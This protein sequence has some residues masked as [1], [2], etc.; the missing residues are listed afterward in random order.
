M[1]P[2]TSFVFR[3]IRSIANGAPSITATLRLALALVLVALAWASPA[4]AR[5]EWIGNINGKPVY[6]I[7]GG[8][9]SALDPPNDNVATVTITYTGPPQAGVFT[10]VQLYPPFD[11]YTTDGSTFLTVTAS[12]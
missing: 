3:R 7:W 11:T 1:R 5:C 6:L 8:E 2:T 10:D 4:D 12:A 9:C